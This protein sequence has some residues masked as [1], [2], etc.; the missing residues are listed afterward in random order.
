[1]SVAEYL[2][3]ERRAATKSEYLDG[4]VFAMSGASR[5]HNLVT[6]D[7]FAVLLAQTRNRGCEVYTGEM[8]VRVPASDLFTYPDVVVACGEPEFDDAELDTLLNPKLILEVLS[9]STAD[10]DRGTKFA[11]YRTIPSLAE[12]VLL[13]QEQ[14]HAEHFARQADGRWLL[15]ET[16]DTAAVLDLPSIGCRL[17]LAEVYRRALPGGA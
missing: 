8:R 3:R 13:E 16:D 1:M 12:Y 9:R 15:A 11:H 6:G 7:A 5:K 14:V 2:A 10:Y 17:A 4:E